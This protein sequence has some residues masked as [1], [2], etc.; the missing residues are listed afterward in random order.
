MSFLLYSSPSSDQVSSRTCYRSIQTTYPGGTLL[1][2][3]SLASH[4]S[5]HVGVT[6]LITVLPKHP[7]HGCL[8]DQILKGLQLLHLTLWLL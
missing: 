3:G 5:Q 4:S 7:H 6:L 8:V 2:G 1:D